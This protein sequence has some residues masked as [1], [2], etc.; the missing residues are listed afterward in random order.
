MFIGISLFNLFNL[1]YH[2]F[3]VRNLPPVDYGHLN[4]LMAV[5][6]L[7]TVPANTVQTTVTKFV[8]S[9]HAK[10]RYDLVRSLLKY[11]LFLTSMVALAIFLIIFLGSGPLASFLKI[12]PRGLIILLGALL[13]FAMVIPV[14]W[15]G[16]Q[17]LQKFGSLTLNL[18]INGV[19]KLLLGICFIV[20]G[21][22]VL[23]AVSA[24]VL[25]YGATIFLSLLM[26]KMSL[27]KVGPWVDGDRN[28][29]NSN[30]SYVSEMYR[31]FLPTG[32]TLL[33]FMVLTNID[34]ILVK[35]FF[36]PIEAGYYSIAQMVG[37]I[38]LFFAH[39]SGDGHV[40]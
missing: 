36:K 23:G 6:M 40:S 20:L 21:L 1:L 25:S 7:I 27:P 17:G 19:L 11:L 9:F 18:I 2:F 38:I 30:P 3:M 5:F 12:S 29:Q 28:S 39:P 37:K 4:T 34:L 33:C 14:P 32:I 15:G 22:G 8:S 16:L 10:R 31:Y 26:L 13:F 35:H 24:I